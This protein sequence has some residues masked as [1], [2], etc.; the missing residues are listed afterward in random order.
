M[1]SDYNHCDVFIMLGGLSG[2]VKGIGAED[3][4]RA[5]IKN[6]ELAATRDEMFILFYK[7]D[8]DGDGLISF[9]E[10]QHGFV[11]RAREYAY[12][13]ETR[14]GFYK[15]GKD[16]KKYFERKTRELLGIFIMGFVECEVSME[17]VK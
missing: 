14:G 3:L 10:M 12:L 17:L 1:R 4:Y 9:D 5:M 7:L 11:P 8:Q 2:G 15:G 6:L 13:V 16:L